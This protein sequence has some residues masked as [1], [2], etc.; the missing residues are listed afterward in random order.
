MQNKILRLLNH[1][2]KL[3]DF[4]FNR[5]N[6]NNYKKMREY[7]A[8]QLITE[9]EE[10]LPLYRKHGLDVGGARGEFS[11]VINK[12]K[13][14]NMVNV[15][16]CPGEAI[17]AKTT[18][19]SAPEL[20]FAKNLFDFVICRGAL[21]HIPSE[22]QQKSVNEMYRVTKTGGICYILIPPWYNPH[23]GHGLKPFHLLPFKIAKSLRHFFFK[24]RITANSY[25]EA[26]LFPITF[27]RMQN[28]IAKSGFELL[29]TKD[30]H[31]RLHFLT[32]I[33]IIREIAV[34]S[35]AFILIKD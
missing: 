31:F 7:L 32:K 3:I 20:P 33:P 25:A 23:A 35:V 19:A 14:C 21:E 15:D 24:K 5:F 11:Q 2:I 4:N 26:N 6:G 28:L 17:W 34:P 9:I 1:Y 18:I 16:P 8:C 29:S 30:T 22:L 13:E 12:T 10:F 27:S